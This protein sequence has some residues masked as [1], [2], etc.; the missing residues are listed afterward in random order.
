MGQLSAIIDIYCS[1]DILKFEIFRG[2]E[3]KRQNFDA[4]VR[5][6]LCILKKK[7]SFLSLRQMFSIFRQLLAFIDICWELNYFK[8]KFLTSMERKK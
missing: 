2:M 7:F 6:F 5:H 3:Q 8:T 4:F 1:Q